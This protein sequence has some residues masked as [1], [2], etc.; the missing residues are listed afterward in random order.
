[1]TEIRCRFSPSPTGSL[2]VGGARTAIINYLYVKQNA[3]KF[4]L[5]IE[6]TDLERSKPEHIETIFNSL[7]WLGIT[8]DGEPVIQSKNLN[9]HTQ[10]AHEMLS[11]NTAYRCFCSSEELDAHREYCTKN[12][13]PPTYSKKCR[14]LSDEE[15]TQKLS[16]NIPFTVRVKVPDEDKYITVND[17]VKGKVSVHYNQLDDFI[18]LRSDNTPVYML[19]VVVDDFDMGI[20]HT[21]RGEDHFTNTFRQTI[22]FKLNNWPIPQFGHLP[23]I[24]GSDGKKLSKRLNA[25]GTDDY[26]N[27]GYLAESL[28]IYLATMGTSINVTDSF[29]DLIKNFKINKLSKSPTQFDINFL[30]LINQKVMKKSPQSF[31]I[32]QLTPFLEQKLERPSTPEDITTIQ[33]A[34]S[35]I[36]SRGKSLVECAEFALLYFKTD[37]YDKSTINITIYDNLKSFIQSVNFE[38]NKTI[39]DDLVK[40]ATE[41]QYAIND[42]TNI[43]RTIITGKEN[44]P[45]TYSIMYAVGKEVTISKF[46]L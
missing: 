42:I 3:G 30:G 20:T 15:I 43:L 32:E 7:K 24:Y 13:I 17:L 33:R 19:S 35:D 12:S 8:Y 14:K 23:L 21:I 16:N 29:D 40:F 44:C 6:D 41:N 27:M 22:I 2:H 39:K 28:K 37:A 18:I 5:R 1:M 45:S 46:N 34:Y 10:V 38:S 36:I 9:R 26:K 31:I 25:V 4:Y 11:N